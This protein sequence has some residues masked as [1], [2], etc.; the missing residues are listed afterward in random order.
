MKMTFSRMTAI[1]IGMWVLFIGNMTV[2][3]AEEE[4][5]LILGK[6]HFPTSTSSDEAQKEFEIG[7]LALHSFWYEESAGSFYKGPKAGPLFCH[8]L[9]GRGHVL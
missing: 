7:V 2:L 5:E 8:G 6:I 1:A 9:L 4:K 3:H